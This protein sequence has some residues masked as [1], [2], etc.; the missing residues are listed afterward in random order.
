MDCRLRRTIIPRKRRGKPTNQ[1]HL[2]GVCMMSECFVNLLKHALRRKTTERVFRHNKLSGHKIH[3]LNSALSPLTQVVGFY[4]APL[5]SANGTLF[6]QSLISSP[7]ASLCHHLAQ[8][9]DNP[10]PDRL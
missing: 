5:R 3:F 9:T 4:V 8:H 7:P 2:S 1:P 6:F 10:A